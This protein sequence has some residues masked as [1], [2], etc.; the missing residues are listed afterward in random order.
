MNIIPAID[1]RRG[2]CVR[3]IQGDIRDEIVYSNEPLEMAKLWI[4][5][6]AK[7]IHIVDIDG[8]LVGKPKN[9]DIIIKIIKTVKVNVEVGGGLRTEADIK[10]YIRAG[11]KRVILST[12]AIL[13][14]EF[15]DDMVKK[16]REKLIIGVDAKN[17]YIAIKGWQ[18]ITQ[19]KMLDFINKL[20]KKQ[21]KRIIFTD[22][23]RDGVLKGPNFESIMEVLKNTNM[24]VIVSGGVSRMKNIRKL[25]E[26]EKKYKNLEGIVIGQALYKGTLD[27]K[28][29]LKLVRD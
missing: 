27:L 18:D 6:G 16:Y 4:G 14:D 17:G 2:K 1:I 15:L 19:V 22:I 11:A 25:L 20:E 28:E 5:K 29:V 24:K 9:M 12:S 8:A 21:I 13:S 26:Y 7:W 10:K 23:K 3:L